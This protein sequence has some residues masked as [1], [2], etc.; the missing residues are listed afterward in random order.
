[1]LFLWLVASSQFLWEDVTASVLPATAE[2]TNRVALAD[3]DSDGRLDLVQSQGEHKTAVAEKVYLGKALPP[4][5]SPPVISMV[6]VS[7]SLVRA[8]VHDLKTPNRPED[9]TEVVVETRGGKTPMRWYG[10]NLF[11]AR[12]ASAPAD[13]RVCATDRKGN[14]ACSQ[15]K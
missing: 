7:G 4:D 10:E 3:V 8:R 14:R 12:L 11:F 5:T 13:S 2:W 15:A 1:L 9:W 6:E